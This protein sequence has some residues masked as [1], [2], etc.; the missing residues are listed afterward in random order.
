MKAKKARRPIVSGF[1]S[2][3]GNIEFYCDVDELVCI[4][5]L[6]TN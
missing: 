6:N 1:A 5:R 4:G 3:K 2:M